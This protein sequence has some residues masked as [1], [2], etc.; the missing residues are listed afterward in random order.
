MS[1]SLVS[2]DGLRLA[3][4]IDGFPDPWEEPE[5]IV[6]IHSMMANANRFYSWMP[7]LTKR[8]RVVRLDMRGHGGS[9]V[10]ALDQELSLSRLVKDTLEVMDHLSLDQAHVLANSS[11]GY[12]AQHL[13]M[14]HPERIKSLMLYA[15]TPGL[16][17]SATNTWIPRIRNEGLEQFLRATITDRF[18]AG[19]ADPNLVE[20]FLQDIVKNN[21]PEFICRWLEYMSPL[22]WGE[23]LDGIKCPTLVVRPGSET[24]GSA[25]V[26]HIM[27]EKIP[28]VEMITYSGMAH[29]ICDFLPDLCAADALSFLARRFPKSTNMH[30]DRRW[31]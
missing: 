19:Y 2:S 26:Y 8:Y 29:S 15:S 1:H 27:Q 22:Y 11:G 17:K 25:D 30:H 3:Y 14:A 24:V 6:I 21:D 31:A 28:D 20:W 13:A 4:Y 5:T 10:P 12:V 18:T 23:K 9:E 16:A 7:A